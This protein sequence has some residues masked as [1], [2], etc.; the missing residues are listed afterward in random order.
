MLISDSSGTCGV[1]RMLPS[2]TI[3]AE[4]IDDQIDAAERQAQ[5]HAHPLAVFLPNVEA[6]IDHGLA[7]R[8]HRQLRAASH[9]PRFLGRDERVRVEVLNLGGAVRRIGAGIELGRFGH[10]GA[11]GDQGLPGLRRGVAHRRDRAQAS[12]HDATARRSSAAAQRMPGH[13]KSRHSLSSSVPS[14]RPGSPPPGSAV[15]SSRPCGSCSGWL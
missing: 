5:D 11:A 3:V 9:A 10:T 7:A 1:T 12:D 2:S 14:A 6:R 15:R 4:R 8:H 13:S